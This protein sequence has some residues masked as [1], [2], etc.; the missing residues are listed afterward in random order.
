MEVNFEN[1][2]RV[3]EKFIRKGTVLPYYILII[4]FAII[5]F[6]VYLTREIADLLLSCKTR[7]PILIRLLERIFCGSTKDNTP[8]KNL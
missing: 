1:S 3:I 7:L 8:K 2:R 6:H 4:I 5:M